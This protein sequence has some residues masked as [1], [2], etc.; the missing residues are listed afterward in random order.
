VG[1]MWKALPAFLVF[2]AKYRPLTEGGRGRDEVT[3]QNQCKKTEIQGAGE[4][5][6]MPGNGVLARSNGIRGSL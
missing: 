5:D 1:S 3:N 6:E 4:D 2:H